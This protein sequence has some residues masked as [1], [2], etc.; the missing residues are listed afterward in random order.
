MSNMDSLEEL[1][2]LRI[3]A[4]GPAADI[5]QDP[6][7]VQ[8]LSELESLQSHPTISHAEASPGGVEAE[9]GAVPAL[10]LHAGTEGDAADE[11]PAAPAVGVAG[12]STRLSLFHSGWRRHARFLWVLSL[13]A[14]ATLAATA[15]YGVVS[16]APVSVSSGARQIGTLQPVATTAIPAG[17]FGQGPSSNEYEFYGLRFFETSGGAFGLSGTECFA[18][19]TT[20][21]L[22]D[23]DNESQNWSVQ[24][25]VPAGCRVGAFPATIELSVS[26]TD[27]PDEL[28]A[29]FPEGSALQ[30]VLVD[31]QIGVF[32]DPE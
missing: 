9:D 28:R 23:T 18:V 7:A 21:Q 31:R 3:R 29:A 12:P 14:S 8:R 24:G 11:V 16:F 10:A 19:V 5:E 1:R 32:L 2:T 27:R 26:S 17:F 6:R 30:F 15:T 22:P 4:Y 25:I 20:D 13:V